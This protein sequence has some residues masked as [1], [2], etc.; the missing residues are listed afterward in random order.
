[1]LMNFHDFN[2]GIKYHLL[3]QWQSNLISNTNLDG[4]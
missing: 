4:H 1:M 2:A 3:L